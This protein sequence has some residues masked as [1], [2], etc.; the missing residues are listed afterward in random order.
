MVGEVFGQILREL[1]KEKGYSQERLA[2]LCD[3]HD[4]YVSML[5]RNLRQPTVTTIFK[6]AEALD[7]E[8][9]ELIMMMEKR[10]KELEESGK[11]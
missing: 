4:R 5:E 3:L 8:A 11:K 10:I 7:M 1:R 9:S 2:E 6:I